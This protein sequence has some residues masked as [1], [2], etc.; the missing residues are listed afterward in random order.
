[1]YQARDKISC[2]WSDTGLVLLCG[3]SDVAV[4]LFSSNAGPLTVV[5]AVTVRLS[6]GPA[7]SPGPFWESVRPF[8]DRA[9]QVNLFGPRLLF[10]F[11]PVVIQ[12]LIDI[13]HTIGLLMI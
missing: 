5:L 13:G 9:Y 10:L 6:A 7:A 8:W 2:Q 11:V 4:D 3:Q 1:M 12:N